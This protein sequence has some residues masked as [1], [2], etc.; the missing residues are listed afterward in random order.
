MENRFV[1]NVKK[2]ID[3]FFTKAKRFAEEVNHYERTYAKAVA[4]QKIAAAKEAF[5][6]EFAALQTI[7][8]RDLSVLKD[9]VDKWAVLVPGNINEDVQL[10]EH[11]F[12]LTTDEMQQIADRNRNNY[13]MLRLLDEYAAAKNA[14]KDPA[15]LEGLYEGV[16][17]NGPAE[18]KAAYEQLFDGG[19]ALIQTIYNAAADSR[20]LDAL[21]MQI[22][23]FMNPDDYGPQQ[24]YKVIGSGEELS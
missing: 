23:S 20:T 4:E 21:K 13:T 3:G 6:S 24:L 22:D 15:K 19:M 7:F 12:N 9:K 18:R 14:A 16:T 17:I 8:D 10:L 11:D 5:D 1:N 2:A